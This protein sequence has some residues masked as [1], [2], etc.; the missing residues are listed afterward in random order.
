LTP[1]EQAPSTFFKA[2][3]DGDAP[4][5][6]PAQLHDQDKP[7]STKLGVEP[8][9]EQRL[10]ESDDKEYNCF[11]LAAGKQTPSTLFFALH[12]AVVPP[13]CPVQLQLQVKPES[14]ADGTKPVEEQRLPA[15]GKV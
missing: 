10:A 7:E 3:Q 13:F 5:F 2:L 15:A 4:P 8:A 1:D 11:P 9:Y 12:G 14:D 6:E